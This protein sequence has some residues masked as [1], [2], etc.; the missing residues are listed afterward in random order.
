VT[1][2]KAAIDARARIDRGENPADDRERERAT[3]TFGDLS[4][5]W[6]ERHAKDHKKSW[7]E[8]DRVVSGQV[9]YETA[10]VTR[11]VDVYATALLFDEGVVVGSGSVTTSGVG[12]SSVSTVR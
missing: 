11:V 3:P 5:A 2:R 9:V 8:D 4:R 10:R 7:Q 12:R 6:L 1:A